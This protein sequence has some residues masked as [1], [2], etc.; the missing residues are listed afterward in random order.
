MG[1]IQHVH[2]LSQAIKYHGLDFT[3]MRPTQ[4][5]FKEP[6]GEELK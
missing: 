4:N 6:A 1:R 2:T 3:V 5:E